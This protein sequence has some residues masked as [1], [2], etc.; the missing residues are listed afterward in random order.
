LEQRTINP[1]NFSEISIAVK[2]SKI[3]ISIISNPI[4][5]IIKNSRKLAEG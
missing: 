4:N 3:F 2:F 5:Q 1:M